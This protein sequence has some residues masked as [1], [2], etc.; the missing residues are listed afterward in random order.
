MEA[1]WLPRT[2]SRLVNLTLVLLLLLP[3]AA[4]ARPTFAGLA[5]EPAPPDPRGPTDVYSL[6][7]LAAPP[8]L[9]ISGIAAGGQHTCA[10]TV[11]GGVKCWG[12]NSVGQ[13]G[14]GTWVDRREPVDVAGLMNGVL[15]MAT[16]GEHSCVLTAAGGVRCWGANTYGQLGDG[17]N[18]HRNTPVEVVGLGDGSGVLAVTAERWHTC[19]VTAAGGGRCWGD[20]RSGQ[21]GDG[22]Y[23]N[24]ST[25]TS[26][27]GL[28]NGIQAISAGG[29]HTCALTETGGV[30][31]W[32]YND[33]GQLGDGT[34]VQRLTA[35]D[36]VG[37]GSGVR[38]VATGGYHTCALTVS[39]GIRCWGNN[40]GGQLGN[41]ATSVEQSTP[42][43]VV[44]HSSGARAVVTGDGHTCALTDTSGV[45]C[46]GYNWTGQLGDST[47]SSQSAPVGVVGLDNNVLAV[48][49]GPGADPGEGHTCALTETG[50]VMCWGLNT[51]GQLGDGTNNSHNTPV[52]VVTGGTAPSAGLVYLGPLYLPAAAVMLDEADG[53]ISPGDHLHLRLPFRNLGTHT[54]EN[55]TVHVTGAIESGGRPQV[56][57]YR[58]TSWL[59]TNQP[60]TLTPATVPPGQTSYADFWIHVS[61]VDP[62]RRNSLAS[63]TWLGLRTT[64]GQWIIPIH[65]PALTFNVAG[66]EALKSGSC[67]HNPDSFEIRRYAQYAAGAPDR[68][69]PPSNDR[70]P[71]TEVQAIRNLVNRVHIEFRYQDI[72]KNRQS[73]I[74]LLAT[75]DRNIGVCR[76]YADLTVGLLRALGLPSRVADGTFVEPRP[77]W[78]DSVVG[79]A[80]AEVYAGSHGWRQADSMLGQAFGEGFYQ[81]TGV[82]VK[83]AWADLFPLSSAAIWSDQKYQCVA[84]CYAA[85]VEC[86]TCLRE[87]SQER[88]LLPGQRPDLSCVQDVTFRYGPTGHRARAAALEAIQIHLQAPTLVTRTVPF[89]LAAGIVNSTTLPLD[90]LTATV[91][92]SAFLDSTTTLFQVSPPF[93]SIT[94][95]NP[96]QA[97]TLTWTLTPLIAASGIPLRVSA[98][99]GELFAVAEQPLLV[100]QPGTLPD[101]VLLDGCPAATAIPGQTLTVTA[102]ALGEYWQPVITA[103]ITATL[104]PTPTAGY[105]LTTHLAHCAA[106]GYYRQVI[107]LPAGWPVGSYQLELV[108]SHPGYD[109]ARTT[110]RLFVTPPLT[111]TLNV[112]PT[113]VLSSEPLTI[114]AIVHERGTPVMD[115]VAHARVATPGGAVIAPLV[116]DGARYSASLRPADLA[117]SLGGAI[118]IGEWQ[119]QTTAEYYGSTTSAAA[120]IEVYECSSCRVFLPLMVKRR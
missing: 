66:H 27:V 62:S 57:I 86:P 79:H 51:R 39:D 75:R 73:D 14:D 21:L 5:A 91:A 63:N 71:D 95:L 58:G 48:A 31:C 2:T 44:G 13:L 26:A 11:I 116:W 15:A 111:M 96:G 49:A 41:G 85:P 112:T 23:N 88:A 64:A 8:L 53:R 81:S 97:I 83:E 56:S 76:D 18:T 52:Q 65:V 42:V 119:I 84:S 61:N 4:P 67:L 102:S 17:T 90:I 33:Y 50:G 108:G 47:Y 29:F 55:A 46:W 114:T 37:L 80:W 7:S 19:A 6:A 105:S 101:L 1:H 106:C 10:L 109:P 35:V 69:T 117:P 24:R 43:D 34:L 113:H 32:G 68:S 89:A 92:I 36:V 72:W 93:Q 12:W 103:A 94:G 9:G 87:S 59:T 22:T 118:E 99:S 70:D 115:A 40:G 3:A 16:G 107:S 54:L 110:A 28:A 20:N 98:Q 77:F 100:N 25:P 120:Q 45:R 74:T 78:F 60:V 104:Y 30:K 38:V 82:V